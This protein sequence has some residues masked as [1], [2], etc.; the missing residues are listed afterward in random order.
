MLKLD[1]IW[2]NGKLI[3]WDKAQ[4]HILTHALHYGSGVFEGIRCYDTG[5][6]GA[7]FR[8]ADHVKRLFYSAECLGIKIPFS[9]NVLKKAVLATIKTNHLNECYIRPIVFCGLGTVG[10]DIS[11]S[12]I[13]AA[14]IVWPWETYLSGKD[15][16]AFVSKFK[17]LSPKA[18]PIDAKINGYYVNS[19]MAAAEAKKKR[20]DEAIL[21]DDNGF[22]AEGPGENIFTVKNGKLYTPAKGFILPGITRDS[23]MKIAEGLNIKVVEKR[24]SQEELNNSDEMFFTGTAVEVCPITRLNGR[25]IGDGKPGKIT[26][27]VK[28]KYDKIVR[29][30]DNSYKKW[31]TYV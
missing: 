2:F 29:G 24:I 1:K 5:R 18:L 22:V 25:K 11:H 27:S 12:P 14:I 4:V 8:L 3:S 31:L 9:P 10:L 15:I 20:A 30:G 26:Q 16:S 7:V 6:G 23:I 28:N 19:I 17:R 21:L 13:Y